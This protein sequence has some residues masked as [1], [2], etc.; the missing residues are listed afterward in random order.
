MLLG[1]SFIFSSLSK[2]FTANYFG[3]ILSSYGCEMFYWLSPVIIL[4]ELL[5][6]LF[7][8]LDIYP[9][10]SAAAT[11]IMLICFTGIYIYG[12]L[13]LGISDCGCYG[14]LK[15]LNQSAVI[16]YIRNLLLFCGALVVFSHYKSISKPI[17]KTAISVLSIILIIAAFISGYTLSEHKSNNFDKSFQ[18][19]PLVE[20]PLSRYIETSAD[21]TYLV[22]VF[23]Y[24][25][26]HCINSM[27]N[28]EQFGKFNVVDRV[29]GLGAYRIDD[30]ADFRKILIP[31]FD[32]TN[33]TFDEI[34]DLTLEFPTTYFIRNDSII[35]IIQGEVPSAYFFMK[36]APKD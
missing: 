11:A 13:T 21:S 14:K 19:I 29:I 27:G 10:W 8:F 30:I 32:V 26:P 18:P 16:L 12:H 36:D 24:S 23:S 25:C 7:L 34:S 6:G 35:N 20:H 3:E 9:K 4:G 5:L 31:S 2:A 15:I 17:S 22:S 1:L 33:Y 28:I